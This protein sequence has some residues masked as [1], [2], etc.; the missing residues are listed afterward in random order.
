VDVR[1]ADT[2]SV[3]GDVDVAL[4]KLLEFELEVD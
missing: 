1:A 4:A 3:N 2:A